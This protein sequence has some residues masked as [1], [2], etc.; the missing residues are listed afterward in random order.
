MFSGKIILYF[1]ILEN[2]RIF[3]NCLF[4]GGVV[5]ENSICSAAF[6]ESAAL[7]EAGSPSQ[8]MLIGLDSSPK[9]RALGS[10]RKLHLFAKA[11]PFGRGG[12]A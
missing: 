9:G 10:P 12:I 2:L 5:E 1:A 4:T 8:S 3:Q 6:Y 7:R 11:S